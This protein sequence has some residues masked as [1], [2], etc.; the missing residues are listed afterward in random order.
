MCQFSVT[1]GNMLVNVLSLK[2][3]F[4]NFLLLDEMCWLIFCH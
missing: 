3:K 1:E 4:A 2:E